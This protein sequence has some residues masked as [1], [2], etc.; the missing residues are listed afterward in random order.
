MGIPNRLSL[1][2]KRSSISI[3]AT[4]TCGV[5]RKTYDHLRQVAHMAVNEY[6][7]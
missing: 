3:E 2:S 5:R 1:R 4:K 7:A 6:L